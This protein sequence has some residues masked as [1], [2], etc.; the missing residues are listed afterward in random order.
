MEPIAVKNLDIYGSDPLEWSRPRDLLATSL[1]NADTAV[2]LGTASPQGRPHSAGVG[3]SYHDGDLYFVSGPG[4]RKSRNVEANPACALSMRLPGMDLVFEGDAH[5]VTDPEVVR[6][7]AA[8]YA[9]GG[10]PAEADGDALTAPYSAPSAGP[11]PWYVYRITV[12]S[13]VAVASAEPHGATK[14]TFGR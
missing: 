4:T 1:A 13:A 2:Y 14:W 12:R 9:A 10:W 3:A 6:E 5:R 11:P 8:V 7:I